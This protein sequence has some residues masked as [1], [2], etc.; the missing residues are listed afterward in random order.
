MEL[1]FISL[2]MVTEED[3]PKSH[4]LVQGKKF[5]KE[6]DRQVKRL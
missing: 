4:D 1:P 2:I 5:Q 3:S 6:S